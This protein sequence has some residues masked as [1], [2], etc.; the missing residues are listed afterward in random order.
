MSIELQPRERFLLTVLALL[1]PIGLWQYLK[2]MILD[3]ASGGV[4][5]ACGGRPWEDARSPD[6]AAG[7]VRRT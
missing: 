4:S 7:P 3:F 1:A 2:P 5:G 6:E